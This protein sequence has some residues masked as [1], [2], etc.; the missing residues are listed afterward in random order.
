[1]AKKITETNIRVNVRLVFNS[2]IPKDKLEDILNN[3]DYHFTLNGEEIKS[4]DLD[5]DIDMAKRY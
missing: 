2:D 3:L 5:W 1:M 4:E